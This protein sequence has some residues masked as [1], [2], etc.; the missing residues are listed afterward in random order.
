MPNEWPKQSVMPVSTPNT[1][2]EDIE[3]TKGAI[4]TAAQRWDKNQ[5]DFIGFHSTTPVKASVMVSD[6]TLSV[7]RII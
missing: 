6:L 1:I 2:K 3:I 7:S 5:M 4:N